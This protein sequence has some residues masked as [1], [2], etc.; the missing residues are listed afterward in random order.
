MTYYQS[1]RQYFKINQE[2][3]EM[4]RDIKLM[5]SKLKIKKNL[6]ISS[7][8]IE[9]EEDFIIIQTYF[10]G[11]VN[12]NLYDRSL[13]EKVN[14]LHNGS[15]AIVIYNSDSGVDYGI[16]GDNCW[17]KTRLS[18]TFISNDVLHISLFA[19]SKKWEDILGKKIKLPKEEEISAWKQEILSF[20]FKD[21]PNHHMEIENLFIRKEGF[22]LLLRNC[23]YF[24]LSQDSFEQIKETI[25]V[26]DD[27]N[28][29]IEVHLKHGLNNG[30]VYANS[31][32]SQY[33][34]DVLSFST[35]GTEISEPVVLT[36]RFYPQKRNLKVASLVKELE[37][38]Y[39]SSYFDLESIS[40]F[41]DE[42]LIQCY[43]KTCLQ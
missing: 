36:P 8:S 26:L 23:D 28:F 22:E 34:W 40:Q 18:G 39:A 29:N 17:Q 24:T 11:V 25:H 14:T 42:Q 32:V 33:Q 41:D 19:D 5:I 15:Y 31:Y 30:G 6:D 12:D 9:E 2:S 43:E 1:I 10:K 13:L 27:F 35:K 20:L 16:Y 38:V 7:Y 4:I 37:K 21:N 3:K